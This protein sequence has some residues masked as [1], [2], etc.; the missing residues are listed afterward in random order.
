MERGDYIAVLTLLQFQHPQ[1]V[2]FLEEMKSIKPGNLGIN[3]GMTVE[4]DLR[5]LLSKYLP[6][7]VAVIELSPNVMTGEGI[8]TR[9]T[10]S[11]PEYPVRDLDL[12]FYRVLIE[13]MSPVDERVLRAKV[14]AHQA[15]NSLCLHESVRLLLMSPK[16]E[17]STFRSNAKA[18]FVSLFKHKR[19]LT[20]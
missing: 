8:T 7:E 12:G 9:L 15:S 18:T 6:A 19:N 16:T 17:R 20:Q 2:G 11:F 4:G 10:S 13:S 3:F 14:H 5:V 1:Y